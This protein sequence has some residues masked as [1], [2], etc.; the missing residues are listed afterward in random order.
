[1]TER[2]T[3]CLSSTMSVTSDTGA[4]TTAGHT[5]DVAGGLPRPSMATHTSGIGA[6]AQPGVGNP[7]A[8]SDVA[9]TPLVVL[10]SKPSLH[11][12]QVISI[13]EERLSALGYSSRVIERIQDSVARS[14]SKNYQSKWKLFVA[15]ATQL[16]RN[17]F[18]ASIPL[19]TE[20]LDYLFDSRGSQWGTQYREMTTILN[21]SLG[22]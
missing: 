4:D 13:G 22:T 2:D 17:P 14:T 10:S 5:L 9:P 8:L 19:L 15:W 6:T 1:M 18:Q 7:G 20:F 3:V 11:G 16:K 12:A 21:S